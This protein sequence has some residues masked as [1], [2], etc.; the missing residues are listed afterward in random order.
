[1]GQMDGFVRSGEEMASG[2][3][4]VDSF[5][6]V[7]AMHPEKTAMRCGERSFTF[8]EL[9]ERVSRLASALMDRGVAFGDRIAVLSCNCHGFA[10][11]YW[12]AAHIGAAVVP[13][14]AR[15]AEDEMRF[16]VDQVQPKAV[17]GDTQDRT[18]LLSSLA[19]ANEIAISMQGGSAEDSLIDYEE[20]VAENPRGLASTAIRQDTPVAIFY[21]AAVDGKPK[22]AVVTHGN[23][24]CQAVQTGN[25]VGLTTEDSHG[26]FLPLSH[27]FGAFLMFVATC[28]GVCN[29]MLS[30][31]DA[32]V[33]VDLISLGKVSFFAEFAPM[34][35]RIWQAADQNGATFGG[36]L[37]F[38]MGLDL[39]P[40]MEKYLSVGVRFWCLYGQ[41]ET[42]GLVTLG[43]VFP[44]K[45][46][47]NYSGTPLELTNISLRG[48][49]G[50]IVEEGSA[51]EAWIR[52]DCVV[53][54]YWPDTP[55]RLSEDGWLQT[56]DILRAEAGQELYFVGR[57]SDKDLIKPGGLNV[58]PAEVEQVLCQHEMVRCAYVFGV[59]DPVWRE[60]VC[61]VVVPKETGQSQLHEELLAVC[62]K[63]LARYK[64]PAELVVAEELAQDSTTPTRQEVKARY[65]PVLPDDATEAG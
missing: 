20:L 2:F 50:E 42:A 54:R 33:A 58:Y 6:R 34:A 29:T 49:D 1:M 45:V 40:T 61:A 63:G 62:E 5:Q 37:R 53:R 43:E 17:V 60:R 39:P 9:D 18:R 31:F 41:T 36:K 48:E 64:R 16:I 26:V 3:N 21:T 12:A 55:T 24:V 51:G 13:L 47:A 46:A 15:L 59:P 38:V 8:E 23:L 52:S 35:E 19:P 25:R 14:D 32:Q 44:S 10:E 56:G 27:T 57:K 22:G 30:V 28:N 7:V 4:L 65:F 11:M